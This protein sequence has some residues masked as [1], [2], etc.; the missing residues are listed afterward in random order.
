MLQSIIDRLISYKSTA[1]AIVTGLLTLLVGVG[2]VKADA[3]TEGV[4]AT[5]Q[6]FEVVIAG[7]GVVLTLVSLFKKDPVDAEAVKTLFK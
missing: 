1:V 6:L 2:V 3:L 4:A 5:G 7:L